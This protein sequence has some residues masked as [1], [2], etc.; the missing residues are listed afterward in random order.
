ML[1]ENRSANIDRT[2]TATLAVDDLLSG[3]GLHA[4]TKALLADLLDAADS[5]RIMHPVPFHETKRQSLTLWTSREVYREALD[6]ASLARSS[7][8]RSSLK[9]GQRRP[10]AVSEVSSGPIMVR[11]GCCRVSGEPGGV[12]SRCPE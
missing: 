4:R 10:V 8:G 6:Q 2:A 5:S 9:G 3:T 11:S 1:K 12:S 7:D